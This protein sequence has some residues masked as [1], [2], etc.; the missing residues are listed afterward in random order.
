MLNTTQHNLIIFIGF[1]IIEVLS[2]LRRILRHGCKDKH[3]I[4]NDKEKKKKTAIF[5]RETAPRLQRSDISLEE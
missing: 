2:C 5:A 1:F 3:F 4:L